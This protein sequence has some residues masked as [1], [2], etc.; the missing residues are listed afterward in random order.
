VKPQGIAHI[1]G[2]QTVGDLG[3]KQTHDMTPRTERAGVIF[4]A[5]LTGQLR[6]QMRWNEVAKL[7]Q[8]R[9]LAG[10]WLTLGLDFNALP[11]GR[12]QTGKPTFF[13][14]KTSTSVSQ[15]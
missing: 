1:V 8:Q 4:D 12:V 9:E 11:C 3:I 7:A 14:S 13:I 10:R 2:T 5:G 15:Q 6:H